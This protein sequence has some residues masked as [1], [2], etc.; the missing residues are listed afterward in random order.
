[1]TKGSS[2]KLRNRIKKIVTDFTFS[3]YGLSWLLKYLI[4]DADKYHIIM[5]Q[6]AVV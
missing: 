5:F 1:M 4:V 6:C 2:H 3:K